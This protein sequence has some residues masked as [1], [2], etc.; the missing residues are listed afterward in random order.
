MEQSCPRP[1]SSFVTPS[2]GEGQASWWAKAFSTSLKKK[3]CFNTIE[4]KSFSFQKHPSK[5]TDFRAVALPEHWLWVFCSQ[6][7]CGIFGL[8]SLTSHIQS[9]TNTGFLSQICLSN[10]CILFHALYY[11]QVQVLITLFLKYFGQYLLSL[12]IVFFSPMIKSYGQKA[13][14]SKLVQSPSNSCNTSPASLTVP[15]T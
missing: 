5:S 10:V 12:P 3:N 2:V 1:S 8:L 7:P 14:W 9:D 13:P 6:A 15:L 11:H 4:L